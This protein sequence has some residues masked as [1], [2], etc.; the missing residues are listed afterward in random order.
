MQTGLPPPT[1]L[2]APA[3]LSENGIAAHRRREVTPTGGIRFMT[4]FALTMSGRLS[5]R[6][7][8][9]KWRFINVTIQ[10]RPGQLAPRGHVR[11]VPR[12]LSFKLLPIRLGSLL[13]NDNEVSARSRSL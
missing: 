13:D 2:D 4:M 3:A 10:I 11:Y 7:I 5:E 1:I 9:L 12:L 6:S 8:G